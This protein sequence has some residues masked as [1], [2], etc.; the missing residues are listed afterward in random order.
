MLR[1]AGFAAALALFAAGAAHAAE[2]EVK[3]LNF[4]KGGMMVLE[5]ALVR[6]APGDT[7]HFVAKDKGHNVESIPEMLP[8]G[9]TP[10]TGK[11]NE[12]VTVTFDKPGVYGVR[13]HPHYPMGMVGLVVVG[14]P[15]NEDA[16]KAVKQ[17]GKAATVFAKLFST[18]DAEK[19][20]AR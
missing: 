15:T 3:T 1:L 14:E 10:F 4:G 11:L 8:E 2:F 17:T 6:I 18:L 12:D 13:C 9:A 19:T 7:V 5:P 20:A 16:A